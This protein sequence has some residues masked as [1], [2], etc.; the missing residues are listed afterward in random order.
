MRRRGRGE[1]AWVSVR[2]DAYSEA[3]LSRHNYSAALKGFECSEFHELFDVIFLLKD[4]RRHYEL[5][6]SKYCFDRF[7][8]RRLRVHLFYLLRH[9]F[10]LEEWPCQVVQQFFLPPHVSIF[11]IPSDERSADERCLRP[12]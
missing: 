7:W 9:P 10:G 8:R 11:G 4:S 1:K 12:R 6:G 2:I 5:F 3:H